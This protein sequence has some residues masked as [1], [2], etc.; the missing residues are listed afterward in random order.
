MPPGPPPL[1][2]SLHES[3][4]PVPLYLTLGVGATFLGN[5]AESGL[6]MRELF[7]TQAHL[8]SE[9]GLRFSPNFALGLYGDAGGGDVAA[10]VREYCHSVG[11]SCDA[12]TARIGLLAR[13]TW[14][15]LAARAKWLSIGT[16]WEVGEVAPSHQGAGPSLFT[17]S[18]REY[19]RLGAGIDYRSNQALGV[20]FYASFAWGEYDRYEDSAGVVALA[21]A[22]HTTGQ[23][24]VRLILFP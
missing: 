17:Y 20:G 5:D 1:G 15:P 14:D 3:S 19:L 4:Y 6:A 9:L 7:Y 23:V 10:P 2:P 11:T 16:G 18:G 24:G 13:Y 21:R 8:S 22:T 12:M